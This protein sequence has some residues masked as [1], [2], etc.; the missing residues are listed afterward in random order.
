[1]SYR[2]YPAPD[3]SFCGLCQRPVGEGDPMVRYDRNG[4]TGI[5]FSCWRCW[6]ENGLPEDI[7]RKVR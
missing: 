2:A 5:W 7:A 6:L 1:M 3:D 4:H